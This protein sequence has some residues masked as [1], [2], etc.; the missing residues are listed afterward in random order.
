MGARPYAAQM[1]RVLTGLAARVDSSA[2]PLLTTRERTA[3]TRTLAPYLGLE[4][5]RCDDDGEEVSRTT[6]LLHAGNST[7]AIIMARTRWVCVIRLLVI[8]PFHPPLAFNTSQP[9]STTS[10]TVDTQPT[11]SIQPP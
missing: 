7:I 11:G 8:G 4:T 3:A 6:V 1:Q 5:I 9:I 2:H 10:K